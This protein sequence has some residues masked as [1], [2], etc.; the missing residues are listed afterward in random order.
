[1]TSCFRPAVI[2][3][4]AM[5]VVSTSSGSG[6]DS[7]PET[8]AATNA[9]LAQLPTQNNSQNDN[10]TPGTT[11]VSV[12]LDVLTNRHPISPYVYGGA[13]PQDAPTI[14]DS[15]LTSV[16]WGGDSTSTYNW[17]L[18]TNNAAN[19]YYYEDFDYSEIGD[20]DSTKYIADVKAAGSAPLMTMPMLPWVAKTAEGNGNGH[21]SFSVAKYGAQCSVDPYNTDVGDGLKSDCATDLTAN[22]NDAYW[23]LLDQPGANDPPGSVYRNSVD[24]GSGCGFRQ[25]PAFLRHG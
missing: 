19:D 24:R 13:Y 1:M 6:K 25:L 20:G 5:F 16:R 3:F 21:W 11:N 4:L 18:F 2:L 10:A 14:T 8:L 17:Q 9:S 7:R 22:P 12:T 23:P 15:G